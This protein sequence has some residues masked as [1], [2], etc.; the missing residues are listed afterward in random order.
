MEIVREDH[1]QH[2]KSEEPQLPQRISADEMA[3]HIYVMK[4]LQ[5]AQNAHSSWGMH[6]SSKYN[7]LPGDGINPDGAIIRGLGDHESEESNR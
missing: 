4:T 7:L 2:K 5:E 6:L 3:Y 1:G